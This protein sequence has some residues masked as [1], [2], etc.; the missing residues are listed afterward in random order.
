MTPQGAAGRPARPGDG[1]AAPPGLLNV[2]NMLTVLRLVFVPLF[3]AC[4]LAGGTAWRL[5]AFALFWAASLTDLLDGW[6][7]RRHGL[8]TD[9]GKVA[10]PIADKFLTGAALVT[11]SALGQLP[12]W[13]TGLILLREFGIT[14]LR[15]AV[16]RHRVIAASRG[17][18]AKTVLQMVAISLYVL[19]GWGLIGVARF[20]VMAAAVVIT[21]LTGAGYVVRAVRLYRGAGSGSSQAR[22]RGTPG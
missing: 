20:P 5:T 4:L 18:K 3:V 10:D 11:L 22:A 12:W 1:C 17:G 21:V 19:P 8:V 9:F 7:A 6:L 2:A 14:A 13:V 15:L 16:I